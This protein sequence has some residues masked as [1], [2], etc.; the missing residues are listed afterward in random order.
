MT[1]HTVLALT[2]G[3]LTLNYM[4]RETLLGTSELPEYARPA[5][6]KFVIIGFT[7]VLCRMFDISIVTAIDLIKSLF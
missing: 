5:Y 2:V 7:L 1:Y 6:T 3:V 4:C